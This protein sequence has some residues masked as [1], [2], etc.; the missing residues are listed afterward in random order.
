MNW[1]NNLIGNLFSKKENINKESISVEELENRYSNVQDATQVYSFQEKFKN[2][3][4]LLHEIFGDANVA[5]FNKIKLIVITDTHNTLQ[6]D[7]LIDIASEHSDYDL[8]LLLGDHSSQ[9]LDKILKHIDKKKIYALLG[10][11]DNNYIDN[12]GLNNLNGKVIDINGVK[13]LGIEGSFKYK[14]VDFPSFTQEES[15]K[16]LKDM[17]RVDIL[18]SHDGP[19][20]DTKV[21]N[22]AH[23]GLFGITY[24]LFKNNVKYNLHGHLHDEYQK[25]LENGT[26]ERCLYSINY[27]ELD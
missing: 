22:P 15:V 4:M 5:T 14:P 9:D 25:Q 12:L 23:Q 3:Q 6:E 7:L 27:I 11:H 19:F 2:Q 26:I 20:D 16:F 24:Y 18:V 8:C 10:N 21:N 13:L 1:F 17:P